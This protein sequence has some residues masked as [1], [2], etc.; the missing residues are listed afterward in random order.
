MRSVWFVLAFVAALAPAA[1]KALAQPQAKPGPEHDV[2]K[3]M[4]GTWDATVKMGPMESKGTMVF[5]MGLGGLWLV[6]HFEGEFGGQ[7]FEGRGMDSYDAAKKKYVSVWADSMVT[8]PM[9]MEGTFDSATKK[10]T[11]EGTG[12]GPDGKLVKSSMV[13]EF[14][15]KDTMVSTMSMPGPDGKQAE[16]MSITYKRK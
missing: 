9:L 15:D 11:M 8:A 6:S 1:S 10:L 5:K 7:K 13:T 3:N 14:K 2:L 12:P 4:E 16:M